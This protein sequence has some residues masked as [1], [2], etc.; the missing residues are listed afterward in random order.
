MKMRF[1]DGGIA[2][3]KSIFIPLLS[4]SLERNVPKH[5]A[6]VSRSLGGG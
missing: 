1:E 5:E 6:E 4:R 2:T 3:K